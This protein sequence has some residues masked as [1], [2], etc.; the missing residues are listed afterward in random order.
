[1]QNLLENHFLV[2]SSIIINWTIFFLD[3]GMLISFVLWVFSSCSGFLLFFHMYLKI[4]QSNWSRRTK[5]KRYP[6]YAYH[7]YFFY[8]SSYALFHY[9]FSANLHD[10]QNQRLS[11]SQCKWNIWAADKFHYEW[12][13][14]YQRARFVI[15][16]RKSDLEW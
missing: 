4:K 12:G 15:D 5:G 8:L 16:W 11:F 3:V 9:L 1:M 14:D 6:I 2:Y 7:R 10:C 13:I